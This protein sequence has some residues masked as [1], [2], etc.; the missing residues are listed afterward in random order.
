MFT[1]TVC[2]TPTKRLI[3]KK[4]YKTGVVLI[5]CHGCKKLHLISDNLGWFEDQPVNIEMLLE[6]KGEKINDDKLKKEA[7]EFLQDVF[8]NKE[9]FKNNN[10]K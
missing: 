5:K 10:K 8:T 1:C 3:N 2:D 9:Y 7:L 6:R 4:A